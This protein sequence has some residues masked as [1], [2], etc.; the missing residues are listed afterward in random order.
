MLVDGLQA[1][2]VRTELIGTGQTAW[3]QGAPYCVMVDALVND[4]VAGEIEHTVHGCWEAIRPDCLI[5]EGQGCLLN[6]AYPGGFEIL[7]AARPDVVV[8]QHAP[9]RKDYDGFFGWPIHPLKHHI[10]AIKVIS[11][12]DVVAIAVNHENLD[13]GE[14]EAVCEQIERETGV[15]AVDPLWQS[16]DPLVEKL[17][18]VLHRNGT[19]QG[20]VR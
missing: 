13:R 10:E 3:L 17:L 12:K 20:S 18:A 1:R 8:L 9:R 5:I 16:V 19:S 6:P 4:F 7:A 2:S 15:V 14:I 11:D